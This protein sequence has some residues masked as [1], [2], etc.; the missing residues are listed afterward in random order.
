MGVDPAIAETPC[1]VRGTALPG[2]VD[3]KCANQDQAQR[4]DHIKIEPGAG[5][6]FQTQ[7][8]IDDDRDEAASNRH[9]Q[10]MNDSN[11]KGRNHIAGHQ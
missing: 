10:G 9:G 7:P 2:A 1:P 5:Q 3:T 8:K 6:E 4:P 11:G